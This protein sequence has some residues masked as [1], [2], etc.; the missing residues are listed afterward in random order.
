VARPHAV[1]R[2]DGSVAIGL[3]DPGEG[4]PTAVAGGAK[5]A[6]ECWGRAFAEAFPAYG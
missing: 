1:E 4:A 3:G 5:M 6:F 2:R